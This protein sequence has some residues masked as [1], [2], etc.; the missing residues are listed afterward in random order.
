LFEFCCENMIP[1]HQNTIQQDA[2]VE[3]HTKEEGSDQ[4]TEVRAE[5]RDAD[6]ER[7]EME[8]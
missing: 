6:L 3:G 7:V 5:G 2:E 8:L 4:G 1:T